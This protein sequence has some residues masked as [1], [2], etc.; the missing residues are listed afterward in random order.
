MSKIKPLHAALASIFVLAVAGSSYAQNTQD[1]AGQSGHQAG[2]SGQNRMTPG[3]ASGD[4]SGAPN[5]PVDKKSKMKKRGAAGQSNRD[6]T[7]GQSDSAHPGNS[8]QTDTPQ[9]KPGGTGTQSGK[10]PAGAPDSN[11]GNTR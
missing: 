4:T 10:N 7:T 5:A 2:Q 1:Q 6:T 9:T 3:D 11:G 8:N